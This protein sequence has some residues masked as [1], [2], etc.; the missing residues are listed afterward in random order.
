M[1]SFDYITMLTS[2]VLA[3]GIVRILMGAGKMVQLR[4]S[5]RIYWVH[6]LWMANVFLWL[7]LNWWILYRWHTHERWTFFL[8]LFVLINPAIGFLQS[9]LLIPEP[10]DDDADL[11]QHFYENHRMFFLLAACVWPVDVV[12][13]LLKGWAHFVAQGHIYVIT[14][15]TLF[16]LNVICAVTKREWFQRV[17]AVFFMVYVLIFISINLRVLL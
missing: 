4:G 3:L 10:L 6:L 15:V 14:V 12:D 13:T 5:I 1:A 16:S 9:A 17:F 8:F 11:K 7:L 2:V